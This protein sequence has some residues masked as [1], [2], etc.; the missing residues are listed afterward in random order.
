MIKLIPKYQTPSKPLVRIWGRENGGTE[1]ETYLGDIGEVQVIGHPYSR[2]GDRDITHLPSWDVITPDGKG[3]R[4]QNV[5]GLASRGKLYFDRV[6]KASGRAEQVNPEFDMLMLGRQLST[7]LGKSI[8][9]KVTST[10]VS[11]KAL[12]RSKDKVDFDKV[13]EILKYIQENPSTIVSKTTV[14]EL[15]EETIEMIND[16]YFRY[17]NQVP[18][19]LKNFSWNNLLEGTSYD[20]RNSI[21]MDEL[22]NSQNI[23]YN[24]PFSY[25]RG[26]PEGFSVGSNQYY[27]QQFY[28]P[29]TIGHEVNHT[30]RDLIGRY[31]F[32]EA[33]TKY[34]TAYG[35]F[36]KEANLLEK[37]YTFPEEIIEYLENN[38]TSILKEKGALNYEIRA[39]LSKENNGITGE[40]LNS[41]IDKLSINDIK[42]KLSQV[43]SIYSTSNIPIS[44]QNLDYIKN[45]LKIVGTTLPMYKRN[46]YD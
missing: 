14:G 35:Y 6:G 44:Q 3:L 46:K 39:L 22:A 37:A 17:A 27:H 1:N 43:N 16:S 45:A 31:M 13:E 29:K 38:P 10:P 20:D 25:K 41:V 9:N 23:V 26:A 8:V 32:A 4:H 2:Q 42:K 33:P 5:A 7:A 40:N 11:K 15:P 21:L 30:F 24:V 19:E 36:P 12:L 34:G 18:K 28:N